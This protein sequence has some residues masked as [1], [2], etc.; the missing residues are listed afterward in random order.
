MC[1]LSVG[2]ERHEFAV[3]LRGSRGQPVP[4]AEHG[5]SICRNRAGRRPVTV[6]SGQNLLRMRVPL[7]HG[8]YCFR[9]N[10]E[11]RILRFQGLARCDCA[12]SGRRSGLFVLLEPDAN[13]CGSFVSAGRRA[14][15]RARTGRSWLA[16]LALSA[17]ILPKTSVRSWAF[18]N[19]PREQNTAPNFKPHGWKVRP[20]K[21]LLASGPLLSRS[22]NQ[23]QRARHTSASER[24]FIFPP[25]GAR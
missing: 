3:C 18:R 10:G 4:T 6:A 5:F 2:I 17:L 24:R 7:F 11:Q 9:G 8:R 13:S 25:V 23:R 14:G 19:C 12:S 20:E 15:R 21:G 1:A 16:P 22:A